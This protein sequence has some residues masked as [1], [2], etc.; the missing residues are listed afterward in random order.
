MQKNSFYRSHSFF[1]FEMSNASK[2]GKTGA[3]GSRQKLSACLATS[4]VVNCADNSGAK[5]LNIVGVGGW[6]GHLNRYPKASVGDMILITVSR[7]G[8]PELRRKVT[9][10]VVVRQRKVYRRAD[11]VWIYFEDNAAV[12]V[13]V[14][15]E[16]K[17]SSINGPVCK[18]AADRWPKISVTAQCVY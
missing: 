8:K 9:P 17:G 16:L 12:I 3:L 13:N 1:S 18:E 7:D 6:K 2:R 4:A 15:G 10:A 11:G 14:K 5:S